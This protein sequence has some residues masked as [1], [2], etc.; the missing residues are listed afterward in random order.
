[1]SGSWWRYEW[2]DQRYVRQYAVDR[3]S[4][5]ETESI[6]LGHF[7]GSN[8]NANEKERPY[9]SHVFLDGDMCRKQSHVARN[10]STEVRFTCCSFRPQEIY[11]ESIT[12]PLLCEYVMTVCTPAACKKKLKPTGNATKDSPELLR[13]TVKT[14]FYHAYDNYMEHAF[15]LDTLKP[16][17]C[18][19]DTFELG[20]IPM[21]TLIDTLD[22]LV[23]FNNTKEFRRAVALVLDHADFNIDT[24]VSVFETTIRV[25]GGLLSAHLFAVDPNL[26]IYNNQNGYNDGLLKLAVDLADRLLPAFV[27][28]TGIPYGTVNLRYGVPRGET[29]VASTAGSGS[30]TMEFTM[31]SVLTGNPVYAI[32]SRKA[33]RAL[34]DRRSS[35]GLLGKHIDVDTGDW[36]ETISGPGSNSDS[37]YEYLLKM[38]TLFGDIES[39]SMFAQVY[40]N[41]MEHN[42]H[43]DW[44]GDV[45][46]WDGCTGG[47]NIIFDNLIAFWPGM[48]TLLGDFSSSAKSLNAYYQVW[49]KYGFLP[50]QFDVDRWRPKK[51]QGNRYPLRPELIEST[52]YMHAATNDATWL[53]A[54]AAF[55]QSLERFSKTTCGYASIADVES[56]TQED[57]M[58]SFFLSETCKYLY[59]LFDNDNFIRHGN[60]VFTTE[61]HPFPVL[62]SKQVNAVLQYSSE[63]I[64]AI[65]PG[66]CPILPFYANVS[67]SA[68]YE[69]FFV[70]VKPRCDRRLAV[71]KPKKKKSPV[72]KEPKTLHGG[73]A[74]GDFYV[75]Q[76]VGGF[77]VRSALFPGDALKVTNLGDPKIV[78]EFHSNDPTYVSEFRIHDFEAD[79]TTRCRLVLTNNETSEVINTITC[80]GALFGPTKDSSQDILIENKLLTM[81][82]PEKACDAITPADDS[83]VLMMR[84]SCY[85]DEKARRGMEAGA[86]A[87][88]IINNDRTE[89]LMIMAK[90]STEHDDDL[91]IPVVM[92]SLTAED[93]LRKALENPSIVVSLEQHTVPQD[94]T[95]DFPYVVGSRYDIKAIGLHGWGL[96]LALK[97][98]ETTGTTSWQLSILD[99]TSSSTKENTEDNGTTN[100]PFSSVLEKLKGLGFSHEALHLLENE[101]D[102]DIR[103]EALVDGLRDVGL[104]DIADQVIEKSNQ[105]KETKETQDSEDESTVEAGN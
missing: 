5:D 99:A 56:R 87:V 30:L 67:Y 44:Y 72:S 34:F 11:I 59:L 14:M 49:H 68:T 21:L 37:F 32:A 39:L 91:N 52:F 43:G 84:G 42:K 31:L 102:A 77:R 7:F 58:P 60:Y 94:D 64:S 81:A 70:P 19:G 6:L 27:T 62:S 24:E 2:C 18:K 1:M 48:Q 66:A 103:L 53:K 104:F 79:R 80:S 96:H 33:V 51:S 75:D 45:S 61:A 71:S 16:I 17:S 13:E 20:K 4:G 50:E 90:S 73:D 9:T 105:A 98:S 55:V 63:N 88:V 85:F 65:V 10:R 101:D 15:P 54:G 46:M 97:T 23:V 29:T 41:V 74:H 57:D 92:V 26:H 78:V 86:A 38:Y 82:T 12:E 25:L 3:V 69:D 100:Q 83:I 35:V 8:D 93:E 89:D 47:A 28:K 22:T 76:L 95:D 36:T 40:T